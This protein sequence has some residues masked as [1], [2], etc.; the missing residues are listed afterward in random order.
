MGQAQLLW[1]FHLKI[2]GVQKLHEVLESL[3]GV[4]L[5]GG[6]MEIVVGYFSVGS[7]GGDRKVLSFFLDKTES[8]GYYLLR[9]SSTRTFIH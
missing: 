7:V 5:F 8:E 1:G 6:G 2:M 3:W 9:I 4:L